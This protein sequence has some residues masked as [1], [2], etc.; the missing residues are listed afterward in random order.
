MSL[1]NR[2]SVQHTMF[3]PV[4]AYQKYV[5]RLELKR[6]VFDSEKNTLNLQALN[7]FV[8]GTTERQRTAPTYLRQKTRDLL[9][10]TIVKRMNNDEYGAELRQVATKLVKWCSSP[11]AADNPNVRHWLKQLAEA[12]PVERPAVESVEDEPVKIPTW[13]VV[14]LKKDFGGDEGTHVSSEQNERD[15]ETSSST[16][17]DISRCED[18][19]MRSTADLNSEDLPELH[20]VASDEALRQWVD[21]LDV[22][23]NRNITHDLFNQVD[24]EIA[25]PR[26]LRTEQVIATRRRPAALLRPPQAAMQADQG[27]VRVVNREI[28]P[29]KK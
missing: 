14:Q 28:A 11:R 15:A 26:R 23:E 2:P 10:N 13:T 19:V 5:Q 3:N 17:M 24:A 27:V 4:R 16:D 25:G 1:S 21:A 9:G 8:N 18:A 29:V 6:K 12:K 7:R 20:T 22:S